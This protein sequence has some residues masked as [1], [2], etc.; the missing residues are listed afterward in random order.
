MSG[1]AFNSATSRMSRY[2]SSVVSSNYNSINNSRDN[3]DQQT[4]TNNSNTVLLPPV[5]HQSSFALDL[6]AGQPQQIVP[7]EP[8]P[9]LLPSFDC[10]LMDF[11]MKNMHGPEATKR[12]RDLGFK[13]PIIGLTGQPGADEGA[14]FLTQGADAVLLKPLQM[15]LFMET[16]TSKFTA[17]SVW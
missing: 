12:I 1:S 17:L 15:E 2:F 11:T 10:I 13:G 14:Y 16:L 6:E 4:T 3:G 5:D 9:P 7:N 8:S